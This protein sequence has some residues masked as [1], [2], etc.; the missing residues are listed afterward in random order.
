M[1]R[2]R[3][4]HL[5]SYPHASENVFFIIKLLLYIPYL[6]LYLHE[7][8]QVTYLFQKQWYAP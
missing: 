4:I 6:F 2:S 5:N 3:Q 7:A 8:G 1:N